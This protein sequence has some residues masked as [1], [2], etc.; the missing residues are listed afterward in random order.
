MKLKRLLSLAICVSMLV[1]VFAG[2]SKKG[3]QT[4]GTENKKTD[5][6][7]WQH[8][9]QA[10]DDMMKTLAYEFMQKNSDIN[11]KTEFIP[12]E[13]YSTKLTSALATNAAP[14]VFQVESG[15]IPRLVKA[16]AVQPLD[17]TV[18]PSD[19]IKSDFVPAAVDGLQV[20]GKYY[21][22]PTD[23]QTIVLYWNKDLLKAENLDAEK[24][25]QT[26]DE[27]LDWAK[28][29]TKVSNGKMVQ[30]GWGETGYHPEVQAFVYTNGGKMTDDSGKYVFADDP[31]SVE[32]IKFM[33]DAYK[34]SK[35]YDTKFMATWAGFR[36]GKVAIMLGHPAMFGNLK[37][38]APNVKL[39]IG[40]VP[41]K[42]GKRVTAVTSWAYVA[43]K[44]ANSSASTKWI[45]YLSS[46]DVE[47]RWTQNTGELP[48][49]KALIN[50]ADLVKDPQVKIL[51][52]SLNDSKVGS[53]QTGALNKI[54]SD[55]FQ[56]LILSDA[57]FDATLKQ[58][59][60]DLN[61]EASKDL[62]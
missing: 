24:G 56:K 1:V 37:K 46:Q 28:K 57:P 15:M 16:D 44:K 3:T 9:S 2:C 47:K 17:E 32:A 13:D 43:S 23:M 29:L 53:L 20:G 6:I 42:D 54:W 50:D 59:Q 39:G 31:K 25:P 19:K 33:A 55:A 14:D 8:S 22:M 34:V 26:W 5:I 61:T 45:E 4:T 21:G 18:M 30:S 38:T 10:R 35:V 48:A 49:R 40:L 52:S 27:L 60:S 41:T 11:I 7:Y 58:L 12:E 62:K 51:L 36:Q